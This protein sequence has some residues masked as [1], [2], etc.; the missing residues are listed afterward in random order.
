MPRKYNIMERLNEIAQRATE[1]L[2]K[3]G[4]GGE[5]KVVE[6]EKR[7][8]EKRR[9]WGWGAWEKPDFI[10]IHN[11]VEIGAFVKKYRA[12]RVSMGC[13]DFVEAKLFGKACYI[14]RYETL[15]PFPID[16][17]LSFYPYFISFI[18][19][20]LI[21]RPFFYFDYVTQPLAIVVEGEKGDMKFQISV[22][23]IDRARL[24]INQQE[25]LAGNVVEVFRQ[26]NRLIALANL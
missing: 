19:K 3:F 16:F 21:D 7:G 9:F 10:F 11:G 6:G 24:E 12:I 25:V 18:R 13:S 15:L 26:F 4:I 23:N 22:E 17:A 2:D 20:D 14:G 1:W 8:G 5:V